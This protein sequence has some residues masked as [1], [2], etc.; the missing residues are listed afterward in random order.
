MFTVEVSVE[1][2]MFSK[3]RVY[4]VPSV[5][6]L[7]IDNITEVENLTVFDITGAAVMSL[8]NKGQSK[9]AID[10]SAL[11]SGLYMVKMTTNDAT[12]VVRFIKK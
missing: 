2:S 6:E 3:V 4:P 12:G 9:V 5:N 7:F 11:T 10:V 1:N 8:V